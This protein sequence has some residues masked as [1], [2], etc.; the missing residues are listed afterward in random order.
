MR[1]CD[2]QTRGLDLISPPNILNNMKGYRSFPIRFAYLKSFAVM[3]IFLFTALVDLG[4]THIV[5]GDMRYRRL[6]RD[7]FE[8][9]LTIRRDCQF[10]LPEARFDDPA[11]VG[12]FDPRTGA[13]LRD[14]GTN[15]RLIM[16]FDKDDTLKNTFVSDC[17]FEGTQ[18]CVQE[19]TYRAKIRLP[20]RQGGFMLAYQ[21][22]CRNQTL[23][24]IEDPL[25]T[26]S[27]YL[28]EITEEAHLS[29]NSSP[30]FVQWPAIYICANLPLDFDHSAVDIDGDSL[31]YRLI[32]PKTGATR[33]RP[34][35]QPPAAPPYRDVDFKPPF[36][37]NNLLGGD[38]LAIDLNTGRLTAV[39][40]AVGQYLVGIVVEEYRNGVLISRVVRDFQYNVRICS[41]PPR[42]D[43]NTGD[44]NCNSLTVDFVNTSSPAA[45]GFEWF[46]NYPD[47]SPAFRSTEVNPSFTFPA[48]GVYDVRLVAIRNTDRC[49]NEITKKVSVFETEVTADFNVRVKECLVDGKVM[50]EF[51]DASFI[52]NSG[53]VFSTFEWSVT[54]NGVTQVFTN[55]PGV[56]NLD[57]ADFSV[58]LVAT[59]ENGCF[60]SVTKFV[61]YS[62]IELTPDFGVKIADCDSD[63]RLSLSATDLTTQNN[64]TFNIVAR[65]W[66]ISYPDT[67]FMAFG[68]T[69]DIVIP[70]T[71]FTITL[72]VEADNGCT[73]TITKDFNIEDFFPVPDFGV[74]L[75]ECTDGNIGRIRL[76][77]LVPDTIAFAFIEEFIWTINGV[78]YTGPEVIIE[79][80]KGDTLR[81]K[82]DLVLNEDCF[83]SK[84]ETIVVDD[85]F[86]QIDF[87]TQ[88]I[89]CPDE[90][91]VTLDWIANVSGGQNLAEPPVWI[92]DYKG[93]IQ[94]IQGD[95]V[96]YTVVKD[97]LLTVTLIG[98]F[99]NGCIDTLV[100]TFIPG[101]FAGIDF[102]GD[103]IV[104][105]PNE[106]VPIVNGS[107]NPN[108]TYSWSPLTGLDLSD[109]LNPRVNISEETKY[110]VTVSDG[111]CT[112]T[113]S[114]LI[115]TLESIE[116]GV[117]GER[118]VCDNNVLLTAT[119]GVGIGQYEWAV[120]PN[121]NAII[122]VGEVLDT[123][124][125]G[126][127]VTYYVRY[128]GETCSAM[129][130]TVTVT[131]QAI[132]IEVF[133]PF[134]LCAGDTI[135]YVTINNNAGHIITILWDT[136]PIIIAGGNTLRPTLAIPEGATG[137]FQLSFE[138][139]NQFG[140]TFRD[141]VDFTIDIAPTVDFTFTQ[142]DCDVF[143]VCFTLQ[144]DFQ[145]VAVWNFGDG[146]PT[147]VGTEVCHTY[148]GPGSYTVSV[149][150]ASQVCKFE[151]V[152]K[153]VILEE[154]GNI[155]E[156]DQESICEGESFTLVVPSSYLDSDYSWC[157]LAGN[158]L[159][160]EPNFIV[161]PSQTTS[162]VL[163][164]EDGNGCPRKDTVTLSVY[165]FAYTLDLPAE[166]CVDEE[167]MVGI[168]LTSEGPFS[169]LWG[170][171]DCV[172]SGGTTTTPI[173][174]VSTSKT[175]TVSVTHIPTGC[176]LNDSIVIE[177]RVFTV[178]VAADPRTTIFL[179]NSTDIFVENANPNWI[180]EWNNGFIGDRQ[181]VSPTET[182]TYT[183]T[184]TDE[185][186]CVAVASITITVRQPN[187]EDDVFIPN[188]F[189]PN[190]D[191]NNDVLFVRSNF[192]DEME[193]IIYNRWGQEVFRSNNIQVGW[194]GSFG[195]QTLSPDVFAYYLRARCVD[196]DEIVKRGNIS[197]LK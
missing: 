2:Q 9:S 97:S 165:N 29:G 179:G 46:F 76:F 191:G 168:N 153:V 112:I 30:V 195:G 138:A 65:K 126:N 44:Y 93:N 141:T 19:A 180:Y 26:G 100:R 64:P 84:E 69:V 190:A 42:A 37:L 164:V 131:N 188:A 3:L 67:S 146:S 20:F 142:P 151:T 1:S 133:E 166:F 116:I 122:F 163:K 152:T 94:I 103:T 175:L 39:P 73:G 176:V 143:E 90:G 52:G 186:G 105:C 182:T 49:A 150:N 55:N 125:V 197:L 89:E 57:P 34:M 154:N 48:E 21:R 137:T 140:C 107:L 117:N 18:V 172:V 170:P 159:S 82:L 32:T 66:T 74:E 38:P 47:Q 120:D 189:S 71:S 85:L 145:G 194:D 177:P 15:G 40:N 60:G 87:T 196:N 78:R 185:F 62:E 158:E 77:E 128:R 7:T 58:T 169:I 22:C 183:V 155:F 31:V 173:V 130:V 160:K 83:V 96:R 10:G 118:D 181:T 56:L 193:L 157:D 119:G 123:T 106:W 11:V 36:G 139:T 43:F 27:T 72:D 35:P 161:T 6:G 144:G 23:A 149:S 41:D 80:E 156:N 24:N 92:F 171:A 17:G 98:L 4:A 99:E 134:R 81:V 86:P 113:D 127:S 28:V 111:I 148:A 110:F 13:F 5:G 109:P 108:F 68:E 132:D 135:E 12:I 14:F 178:T 75:L 101:P 59:A 114:I 184:V 79:A 63:K 54:Q 129:P 45:T 187:C 70:N 8:I 167:T 174:R 104:V 16:T 121:F 115:K 88:Q 136:N 25:E 192:V 53:T 61:P 124:F 147:V 50:V 95:T 102:L 91:S 162:Y 33:D 51:E